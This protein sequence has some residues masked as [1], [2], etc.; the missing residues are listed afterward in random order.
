MLPSFSYSLAWRKCCLMEDCVG[1]HLG[2]ILAMFLELDMDTQGCML[3]ILD[4]LDKERH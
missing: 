2:H 1:I 3:C 4:N